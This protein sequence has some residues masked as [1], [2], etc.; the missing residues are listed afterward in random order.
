[1]TQSQTPEFTV[2]AYEKPAAHIARISLDRA[3]KR[4]AQD[5]DL[6]YE[7]NAAMDLANRDDEVKVIIL[8]AKGEHFSAGHDVTEIDPKP[9]MAKW[10]PIGTWCGFGCATS[11]VESQMTR[12]KEIYIGFSERWRNIA[13]PTIAQVQGKCISG[14]LMLV[15]PCDLIVAAEDALFMDNTVAM[16]IGGVE[17]FAHPWEM[18][19]RQAKEFL[20]TSGWLGAQ[21]AWRMGMVNHVVA[22]DKLAEFTLALAANIAQKPMF[23][24]KL[25]KEAL[26]A[27]QDAQ[28]R[29][30]A[31]QTAFAL[32]QVA[33]AHNMQRFG[34]LL[35]PSGMPRM[36]KVA[37]ASEPTEK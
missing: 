15:W 36:T 21:D 8:A 35:D 5:T 20:F 30:S 16:G 9:G 11:S 29:V 19:L 10:Q 3:D 1:M 6:L 17:F 34:M 26:N 13:K 4:N 24:L 37:T 28:G 14:G 23:A 7:L 33:H 25:A 12:E 22:P 18:G 27:A 32:H 2:I 31:M